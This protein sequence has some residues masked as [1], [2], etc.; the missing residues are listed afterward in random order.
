MKVNNVVEMLSNTV[1]RFPD[2]DVFMWKIDGVYQKMRYGAFW[3][4][5][6]HT[7]S[8]LAHLGIR[9]DD[10]V[11]ILSNSNPMWGITDYEMASLGA[12]SVPMYPILRPDRSA[13]TL[14]N[15]SAQAII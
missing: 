3:E 9:K 6:D 15:A 10:K 11:A 2:K 13:S 1:E 7:A 14:Y 8:G 5:V 12:V 4:K